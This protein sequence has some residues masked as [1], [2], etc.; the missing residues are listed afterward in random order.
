MKLH[1]H[2]LIFEISKIEE[3]LERAKNRVISLKGSLTEAKKI[4]KL[5]EDERDK[6]KEQQKQ[7][8]EL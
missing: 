7:I 5:I 6:E 1:K 8:R 3:Q 4:S 2:F